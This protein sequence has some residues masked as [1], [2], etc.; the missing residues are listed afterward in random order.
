MGG[1]GG[2]RRG[3][4]RDFLRVAVFFFSS[5]V[6]TFSSSSSPRADEKRFMKLASFFGSGGGKGRGGSGRGRR[7]GLRKRY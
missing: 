5:T 2:E 7:G 4:G 3:R 6:S 1:R